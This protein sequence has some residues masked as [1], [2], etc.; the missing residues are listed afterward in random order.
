MGFPWPFFAAMEN[1]AEMDL[2]RDAITGLEVE[3]GRSHASIYLFIIYLIRE[4]IRRRGEEKRNKKVIW[5][6]V[7]E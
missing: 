5:N 4:K 6:F 7:I 2:Y 1:R 3:G